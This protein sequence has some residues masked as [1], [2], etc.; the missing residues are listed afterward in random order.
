MKKLIV[1]LE[2]NG[3]RVEAMRQ[4]LEDRLSMYDTFFSDTPAR[5]IDVLD[6]E[7]ERVLAVSLDHDLLELADGRT[8]LTGMIVAEHLTNLTPSFPVLIHSS[9]GREADRMERVLRKGRWTV[10]R[11]HPFL[12]T[13]WIGTDWYPTLRK[14]IKRF[15]I[16]VKARGGDAD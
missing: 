11:V 13:T 4:W 2:D 6:R 10:Y 16:P 15:A 5:S 7:G 14:A 3:D 9:N 1:V 12:D 8:D